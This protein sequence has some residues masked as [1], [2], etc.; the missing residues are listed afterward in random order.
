[1]NTECIGC[2]GRSL[3]RRFARFA[4]TSIVSEPIYSGGEPTKA[5]SE[6]SPRTRQA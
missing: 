1:M 3:N 4:V 6:S 5:A 2:G